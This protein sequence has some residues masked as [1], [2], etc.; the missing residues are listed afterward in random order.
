MFSIEQSNVIGVPLLN[1]IA[2]RS[3][4]QMDQAVGGRPLMHYRQALKDEI[5][6]AMQ[7][8]AQ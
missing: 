2:K 4:I 5:I 6:A 3:Q 7:T 1:A 8:M